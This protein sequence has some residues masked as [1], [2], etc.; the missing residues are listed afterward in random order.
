VTVASYAQ[1]KQITLGS[2][3]AQV[4]EIMGTPRSLQSYESLGQ[5]VWYYGFSSI[6][7]K[8]GKVYEWS[9]QGNLKVTLGDA[10]VNA[11]PIL[12]GNSKAQ[13]V[14]TM[15][16]PTG[17]QKYPALGQETWYYGFSSITFK[18]DAV[19]EWSNQG[20]LN[21][22]MG[23]QKPHA[24]PITRGST[25][26]EVVATIG[27]PSSV[28]EYPSLGE[29]VWY[30]GF[31][32]I[33]F[34]NARV[35]EWSNSGNLSVSIGEQKQDAAPITLGSVKSAVIAAMGT[36]S[37]IQEY[38]SLGQEVWYYDFSSITFKEGCVC[39]WTDFGNLHVALGARQPN[40]PP[41]QQG[42]NED[43]VI[44]ALGTP[45]S[46]LRY[47]SLG[48]EV[49][50][51]NFSSITFRGNAVYAWNDLGDLGSSSSKLVPY[52]GDLE[53]LSDT[54]VAPF[55]NP[56]DIPKSNLPQSPLKPLRIPAARDI[57]GRLVP[58]VGE[59]GSYFG[60][61]SK[62]TGRPKTVYVKGYFRKDGTYVRSHFRSRPRR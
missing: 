44:K 55:S 15:G 37:S 34:K 56:L 51:F 58:F 40:A 10:L 61:I 8:D 48:E 43:D 5:E 38:P 2:S 60:E 39:E 28:Q 57:G 14:A 62:V 27:T 4:Q 36:P 9:N 53:R 50:Y 46:I 6:T 30:Y 23:E 3:K 42:S 54:E 35:A 41:I 49:S 47:E 45:T 20:N 21:V 25:K 59:N 31:S 1:D 33:T 17:I 7:F 13:V 52:T 22:S 12:R 18:H 26:T 16:T 24:A 32:S 29:E 19:T 11:A